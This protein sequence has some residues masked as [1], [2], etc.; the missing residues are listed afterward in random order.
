VSVLSQVNALEILSKL[1][2]VQIDVSNRFLLLEPEKM[3]AAV[4]AILAQNDDSLA[5]LDATVRAACGMS[6]VTVPARLP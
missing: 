5:L 1:Y 2:K 3:K 4:A 6:C